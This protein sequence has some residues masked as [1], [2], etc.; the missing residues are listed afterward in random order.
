MK[1]K[2][3]SAG[4][5]RISQDLLLIGAEIIASPLTRLINSSIDSGVFPKEKKKAVE[6]GDQK[7]LKTTD[8]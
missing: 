2:K 4:Q 1:K 3:K 5:N 8:Q 7:D 6:K